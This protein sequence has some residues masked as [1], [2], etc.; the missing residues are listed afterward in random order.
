MARRLGTLVAILIGLLAASAPLALGARQDRSQEP[1]V[2]EGVEV[3]GITEMPSLPALPAGASVGLQRLTFEAGGHLEVPYQGPTLF[4]V[5]RGTLGLGPEARHLAYIVS[6]DADG[7]RSAPRIG[8]NDE[9]RVTRGVAVYAEDG[10][11]GPVRNAG[12]DPLV[13]LALLVVPAPGPGEYETASEE[14]TAVAAENPPVL[15]TATPELVD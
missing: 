3:D 7:G 2:I 14:M 5:E 13:V 9:T 4:Y 6:G 12:D 8:R 10:D 1:Y 15:A 11:L